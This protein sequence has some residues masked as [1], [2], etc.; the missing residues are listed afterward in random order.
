MKQQTFETQLK[1]KKVRPQLDGANCHVEQC[2]HIP[3]LNSEQLKNHRRCYQ[4]FTNIKQLSKQ[5]LEKHVERPKKYLRLSVGNKQNKKS[6]TSSLVNDNRNNKGIRRLL[7]PDFCM[8]CKKQT[9][10]VSK[11]PDTYSYPDE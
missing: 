2:L 10:R 3:S 6:S 7:F 9:I 1:T 8:I 5:K 4:K 11:K